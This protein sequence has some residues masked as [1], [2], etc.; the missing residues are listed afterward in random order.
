MREHLSVCLLSYQAAV[1]Q[2]LLLVHARKHPD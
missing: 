1:L 2:V